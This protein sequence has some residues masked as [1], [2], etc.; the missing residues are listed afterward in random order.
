MAEAAFRAVNEKKVLQMA[1]TWLKLAAGYSTNFPIPEV[2][3]GVLQKLGKKSEALKYQQSAIELWTAS[4]LEN[5]I[6]AARLK[7]NLAKMTDN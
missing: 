1:L 5:E 6:I 3:A 7:D 4:K 2:T